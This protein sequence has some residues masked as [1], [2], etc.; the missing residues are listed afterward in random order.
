MKVF[1]FFFPIFLGLFLFSSCNKN[2]EMTTNNLDRLSIELEANM[3]YKNYQQLSTQFYQQVGNGEIAL[4]SIVN[5]LRLR[6]VENYCDFDITILDGFLGA[7]KFTD[8]LCGMLSL[9]IALHQNFP[10]LTSLD[11]DDYLQLMLTDLSTSDQA[12]ARVDNCLDE[13]QTELT[14]GELPNGHICEGDMPT[15]ILGG[16][17]CWIMV[18]ENAADN[19]DGCCNGGGSGCP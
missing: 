17:I 12:T 4:S 16:S 6:E 18:I 15:S 9:K 5:E 19:Y 7:A 14:M 2:D 3:H 8:G 13:F 11:A 10:E 1:K